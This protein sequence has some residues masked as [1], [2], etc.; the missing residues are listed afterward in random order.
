MPARIDQK[1]FIKRYIH[2]LKKRTC[3]NVKK[4]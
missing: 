2:A 3:M 4:G 1:G